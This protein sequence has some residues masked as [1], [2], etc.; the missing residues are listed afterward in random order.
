MSRRAGRTTT[1]GQGDLHDPSHQHGQ[2]HP[3][4][5]G[6]RF[7]PLLLQVAD[8]DRH[9]ANLHRGDAVD[10]RPPELHRRRQPERQAL[11]E[12]AD[13]SARHR[14]RLAEPASARNAQRQSTQ[15]CS[16]R[17]LWVILVGSWDTE[18]THQHPTDGLHHCPAMARDLSL[19]PTEGVSHLPVMLVQGRLRP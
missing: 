19:N 7:E 3:A 17:P 8:V 15:G 6:R 2:S 11:G 12:A 1:A 4:D 5:R 9:A 16:D 10:E 13:G 18:H 14:H